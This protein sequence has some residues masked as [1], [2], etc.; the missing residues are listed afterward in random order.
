MALLIA[1]NGKEKTVLAKDQIFTL[2]ELQR[3]C[4]TDTV[5]ALFIGNGTVVWLDE[6][7]KLKGKLQNKKATKLLENVLLPGDFVAGEALFT[8]QYEVE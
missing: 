5:Q 7:A 2:D 6:N 8:T 3:L 4:T 1:Q